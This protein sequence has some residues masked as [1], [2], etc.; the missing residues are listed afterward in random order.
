[1]CG[2]GVFLGVFMQEPELIPFPQSDVDLSVAHAY[3]FLLLCL[4]WY[5]SGISKA[6]PSAWHSLR[7]LCRFQEHS[8][9]FL[10]PSA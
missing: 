10:L 4:L 7:S 5:D 1:M 6:E 9:V 2:L 3:S 8:G